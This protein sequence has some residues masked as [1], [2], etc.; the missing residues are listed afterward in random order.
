MDSRP[1]EKDAGSPTACPAK[2]IS[3]KEN[4]IKRYK[5]IIYS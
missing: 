1:A 2:Y 4:L 5:S 3:R